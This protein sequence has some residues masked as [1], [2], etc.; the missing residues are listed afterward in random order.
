MVL[1]TNLE[2]KVL[3]KPVFQ[4]ADLHQGASVG[5]VETNPDQIN[6]ENRLLFF[7]MHREAEAAEELG[8]LQV[9]LV[10]AAQ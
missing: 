1:E 8:L 5:I 4:Q 10:N 9:E 3:E 2:A 6:R 7:Q